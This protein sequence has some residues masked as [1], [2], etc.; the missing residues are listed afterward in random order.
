MIQN[1]IFAFVCKMGVSLFHVLSSLS[2]TCVAM[3][4]PAGPQLLASLLIMFVC[5][6]IVED[7][8]K[9]VCW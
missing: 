3:H 6:E 2:P 8:I 1:L 9:N 4:W 5:T 7:D